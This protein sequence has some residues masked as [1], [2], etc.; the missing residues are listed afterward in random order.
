ML[1]NKTTADHYN[2][3]AAMADAVP[4]NIVPYI[5]TKKL[6]ELFKESPLLNNI[7][8]RIFDAYHTRVMYFL[9]RAGHEK[10]LSLAENTCLL[11]HIMVYRYLKAQPV[12]EETK[13]VGLPRQRM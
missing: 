6:E 11:K 8:L 9:K 12:F 1:F 2:K 4:D 13:N 10:P 7:P 5:T 3:Y